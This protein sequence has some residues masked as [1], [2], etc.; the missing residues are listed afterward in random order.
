MLVLA[1]SCGESEQNGYEVAIPLLQ[2]IEFEE[3]EELPAIQMPI[4][5][6]ATNPTQRLFVN[7]PE[8]TNL[9]LA[10]QFAE[11]DVPEGQRINMAMRN[12]SFQGDPVTISVLVE[13]KA[14]LI[15]GRPT[16]YV[17]TTPSACTFDLDSSSSGDDYAQGINDCL[18]AWI[19][20][21]GSPVD[22][23]MQV[24]ATP[25]STSALASLTPS[26]G[27]KQNQGSFS[28]SGEWEMS[29]E[30]ECEVDGTDDVLEAIEEGSDFFE[31][32]E[33]SDLELT[34]VGT[35]DYP[36]DIVGAAA[37]W[38]AC[39]NPTVGVLLPTS[40]SPGEYFV[41]LRGSSDVAVG[42]QNVPVVLFPDGIVL[43][44]RLI[45]AANGLCSG[46]NTTPTGQARGIAGWTHCGPIDPPEAR[47]GRMRVDAA[48]FCSVA[49]I[50]ETEDQ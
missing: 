34:G 24:T 1:S 13:S 2:P 46:P 27:P 11:G 39:G 50:P 49:P 26:V 5:L 35:T 28:Y 30:N 31:L 16:D 20:E 43:T 21:N 37:V 12:T 4:S 25:R 22:F 47:T 6:S 32:L 10:Q 29:S 42:A 15:V 36:I 33:C 48:G 23:D 18:A 44:E 45:S 41:A 19:D 38:D 17:P 8:W 7:A 9:F 3:M 40:L 14:G